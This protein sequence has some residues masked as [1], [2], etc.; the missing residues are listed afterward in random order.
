MPD[1]R[2]PIC[3]API[4]VRRA[5]EERRMLRLDVHPM[6]RPTPGAY[7]LRID[8]TVRRA[9]PGSSHVYREHVCFDPV[10]A[11]AAAMNPPQEI[12]YEDE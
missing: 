9:G 4:Q 3:G 1:E 10:S 11:P 12:P 5:P 8:H 7:F 6:T 2:C